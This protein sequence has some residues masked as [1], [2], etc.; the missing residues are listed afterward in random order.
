MVETYKKKQNFA[1]FDKFWYLKRSDVI[2]NRDYTG[3]Y[4]DASE[5]VVS[6]LQ[7]SMIQQGLNKQKSLISS[8]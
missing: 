7:T 5:N 8:A 1:L 6:S 2:Q 4:V 3:L